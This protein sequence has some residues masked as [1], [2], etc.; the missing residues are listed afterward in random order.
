MDIIFVIVGILGFLFAIFIFYRLEQTED[1]AAAVAALFA[2]YAGLFLGAAMAERGFD[3]ELLENPPSWLASHILSEPLLS[4]WERWPFSLT[5]ICL[6]VAI[7]IL[8][9]SIRTRGVF[10]F[11]GYDT[12]LLAAVFT[13]LAFLCGISMG[14]GIDN[15]SAILYWITPG[16]PFGLVSAFQWLS[17]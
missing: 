8:F 7:A 15:S 2:T 10:L 14:V 17:A 13:F 16:L 5:F 4:I 12:G 6:I 9:L 11:S 3:L 1:F